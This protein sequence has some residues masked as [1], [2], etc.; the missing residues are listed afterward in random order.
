MVGVH[1]RQRS[2]AAFDMP[3]YGPLHG[4][5]DTLRTLF[6]P[7]GPV[8]ALEPRRYRDP[9]AGV[10][11]LML[12]VLEGAIHDVQFYAHAVRPAAVRIY[13]DAAAW[14]AS[15]DDGWLFGFVPICDA[16]GFAAESLRREILAGKKLNLLSLAHAKVLGCD[17]GQLGNDNR[18]RGYRRARA[19][20]VSMRPH[21][22]LG[23]CR[24][25]LQTN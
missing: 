15:D 16:L 1:R 18:R 2:Q 6:A 11:A 9:I 22:T 3:G 10:R 23:A 17:G 12:A 5:T 19:T 8:L 7:D 13:R 20:R 21:A 4:S 14:L 24:G 25:G